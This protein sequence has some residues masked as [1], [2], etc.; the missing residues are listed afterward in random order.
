MRFTSLDNLKDLYNGLK[1][2]RWADSSEDRWDF[3]KE[4]EWLSPTHYHCK[5]NGTF[6]TKGWETDKEYL[7][8][9]QNGLLESL[10]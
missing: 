1:D 10:L 6:G 9:V 2:C 5:E 4:V 8:K 7:G 3:L